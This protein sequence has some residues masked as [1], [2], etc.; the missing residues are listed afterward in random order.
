[1]NPEAWKGSR[2]APAGR[3]GRCCVLPF[4]KWHVAGRLP[5]LMGKAERLHLPTYFLLHIFLLPHIF[6]IE[7]LETLFLHTKLL[8][9]TLFF[10]SALKWQLLP[11]KVSLFLKYLFIRLHQVLVAARG[12]FN[13]HHSTWDLSVAC[14]RILQTRE[15]TW[16]P[17]IGRAES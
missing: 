1:M 17:C 5:A 3:D 4:S 11:E 13:L 12:F 7:K 14:D 15:R 10:F 9:H 16:S 2:P 8:P 6:R